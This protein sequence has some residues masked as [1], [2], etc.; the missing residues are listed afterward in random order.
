M[1]ATLLIR[2]ILNSKLV[3]R[4]MPAGSFMGFFEKERY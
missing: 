4:R 3:N 1:K 2:A